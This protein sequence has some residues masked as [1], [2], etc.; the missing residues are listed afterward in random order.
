MRSK[1]YPKLFLLA[2]LA[3]IIFILSLPACKTAPPPSLPTPVVKAPP[4]IAKA[5]PEV[6]PQGLPAM[7]DSRLTR[8]NTIIPSQLAAGGVPG[9]VV[10][11]GYQDKIVY[12]QAF[13]QRMVSPQVL[14]MTTDTIFDIA[15]LTKVVATTTAIMQLA[16]AGKIN[17]DKPVATY[18]S[19]LW[20][21]RQKPGYHP[22]AL[23]PQ[24][25]SAGRR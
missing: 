8:L 2:S 5:E 13:G 10:I 14:P 21:Q 17:L 16:D 15:S 9:A 7:A 19:G 25:R 24:L 20:R 23:N 12:R 1:N 3:V 11:V 22:A 4:V 6:E 18:W